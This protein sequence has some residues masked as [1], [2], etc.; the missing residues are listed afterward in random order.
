MAGA[1]SSRRQRRSTAVVRVARS[2][3]QMPLDQIAAA[4]GVTTDKTVA[5]L[6]TLPA[7]GGCAQTLAAAAASS[8]PAAA[9][10]ALVSRRCPPP[11]RRAAADNTTNPADTVSW[12]QRERPPR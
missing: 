12:A 5:T 10:A 1:L 8:N 2:A 6:K 3:P 4:V 11:H 9:A 7:R